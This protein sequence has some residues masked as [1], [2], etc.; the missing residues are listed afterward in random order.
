MNKRNETNY[1]VV[2]VQY[3]HRVIEEHNAG[4][5]YGTDY[6][7]EVGKVLEKTKTPVKYKYYG[8]TEGHGVGFD[9]PREKVG[10]FKITKVAT[11]TETE[12]A[13]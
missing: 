7:F 4:K 12:E 9:I 3:E 5:Y 10:V 8:T 11:V 1:E 2:T 13:L 6:I